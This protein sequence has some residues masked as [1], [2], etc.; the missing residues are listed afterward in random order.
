MSST[1]FVPRHKLNLPK[2]IGHR[3]ACGYAPENTLSSLR[4]AHELGISW[5]EFDVMLTADKKAIIFHDETLDRTTNGHGLVA[6]TMLAD[7]QQLDAG[8]WFSPKFAH[9]KVPTFAEYLVCA[10]ELGL[11]MNIEIKPTKGMERETAI[12]TMKILHQYPI[13][14]NIEILISSFS[15][16][17]LVVARALDSTIPM[18]LLLHRWSSGWFDALEQLNCV[19]LNAARRMLNPRVVADI[20][21][22]GRYVMAYTVDDPRKAE[23]LYSWGVDAVFSNRLVE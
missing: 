6:R 9:E 7:I 16:E 13:P 20:K 17:S 14:I 5:V 18:G 12:E 15:L 21:A 22:S 3:G 23:K 11:S 4:K 19:S 10:T 1:Q 2:I 8:S